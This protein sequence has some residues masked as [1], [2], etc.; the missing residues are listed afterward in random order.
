MKKYCILLFLGL[1]L[2]NLQAQ[3]KELTLKDAVLRQWSKFYPKF[4]ADMQWQ[5]GTSILTYRNSD[6]TGYEQVDFYKAAKNNVL[7]NDEALEKALGKPVT[8]YTNINWIDKD[9]FYFDMRGE[10]IKYN[11]K[12]QVTNVLLNYPSKVENADYHVSSNQLAYT[13]DNN[14]YLATKDNQAVEVV[15]NSDKNIVTGQAIA[16]HEFGISKGT[17]WSPSGKYL[18]FYQKD[19]TDVADYPLL[20]ISETP[21]KVRMIKYPMAGQKSEKAKVGIYNT[22]TKKT[23]YLKV[24]GP[25]DQYL[26]N[27]A[28]GPKGNYVYVALLNRDQNH[29]KLQK[30]NANKGTLEKV[31]F[32]EKHDKYVEPEHAPWFLPNGKE[33]LWFSERDGFMHLYRYTVEGEL[34]NQVT[35]GKW[36]C[37][38]I[39]GLN[40][41][42]KEII[43]HGTDE[44]G[45]NTYAYAANLK[46]GNLK[47]IAKKTDGV[48]QY[49]LSKDGRYLADMFSNTKTPNQID[50]WDLKK[51]KSETL[52]KAENPLK[53]YKIGQTEMVTLKAEDGTPLHGRLIK[54]VD[55]D[56]SKKY[57]VIV[58]VYGG[59]HA[60]MVNNSWLGGARLWMHY[61]AQRGYVVFTLDNRGSS[62]RGFEFE[63][64][65]HRQLGEAEMSDQLKGVEYLKGLSYVDGDRMAVHGWSFGGFMTTSLMLRQPGTFQVGVAGGPVTDWKF[66]E[67]MYGERYMDRPEENP[68]GYKKSSLLNYAKE[69]KGDLLLIH[70]TI[71]D[72]VVMQ[73]NYALVEAFVDAEKLVDFFPY[74]MHPHNVRGKDRLHLMMK[75]LD[76]IDDKL[77]ME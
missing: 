48:H 75:V 36:V 72:V 15:V 26:T 12:D 49:K 64:V 40:H 69:L 32:E 8:W 66:Y 55:F 5:P 57:P 30:Y 68:E 3:D 74:P 35:K 60:Q 53:E 41:N 42:K 38:D 65:I 52:L 50:L 71:D 59:P 61:A 67:V 13:K 20:D 77:G 62:N 39:L 17:F 18:A 14:L 10:Y 44:T 37:L 47:Q 31:L 11:L 58:Y 34:L 25:S 33:F 6:Y 16:R 7:F 1:F 63:N 76:Y 29:M 4:Y 28:W 21:G 9:N 22:K 24:E 70:G 23:I 51:N 46:T 27:L 56:A 2:V 43:V 73:H 45:L 54:P 19:E